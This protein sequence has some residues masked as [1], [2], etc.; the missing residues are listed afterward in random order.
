MVE[1]DSSA[2]SFRMGDQRFW[3]QG[4]DG[5]VVNPLPEL[6]SD[7]RVMTFYFIT[8]FSKQVVVVL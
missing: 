8:I 2:E 6:H 3:P 4:G 5:F 7:S 1:K